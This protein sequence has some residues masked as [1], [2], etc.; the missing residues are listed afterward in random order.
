MRFRTGRRCETTCRKQRR[1]ASL[2]KKM[3]KS[4]NCKNRS[5]T[6]CVH[7]QEYMNIYMYIYICVYIFIYIYVRIYVDIYMY[8][9]YICM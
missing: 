1:F 7:L 3:Y 4:S 8:T 9:F 2:K 6:I 5:V